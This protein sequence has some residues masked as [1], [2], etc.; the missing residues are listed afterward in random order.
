[1]YKL[2]YQSHEMSLLVFKNC[3][4]IF[5][6]NVVNCLS[7][8]YFILNH[9]LNYISFHQ[10]TIKHINLNNIIKITQIMHLYKAYNS[11]F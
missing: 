1:M 9:F 5:L 8:C 3:Y 11:N 4:Q 10:M 7:I 6:K 2:C